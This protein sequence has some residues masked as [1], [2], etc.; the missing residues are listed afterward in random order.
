VYFDEHCFPF[1]QRPVVTT[2]PSTTDGPR[3]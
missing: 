2:P 1:A 3:R